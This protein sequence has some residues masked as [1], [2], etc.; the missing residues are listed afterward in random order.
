MNASEIQGGCC[1][2]PA[3]EAIKPSAPLNPKHPWWEDLTI[4]FSSSSWRDT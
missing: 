2:F 4:A 3:Q 1:G